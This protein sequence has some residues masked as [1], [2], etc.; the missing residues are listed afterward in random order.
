MKKEFLNYYLYISW[1]EKSSSQEFSSYMAVAKTMVKDELSEEIKNLGENVFVISSEHD[2]NLIQD[3]LKHRRFPYMLV[4]I[5]MNIS[6]SLI[7]S[8]LQSEEIEVLNTFV[9]EKKESQ[10]DY[11]K[12]KMQDCVLKEDYESAAF[13]RDLIIEAENVK[14][15]EKVIVH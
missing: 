11:L 12:Y 6:S 2:F 1:N 15:T 10:I 8:Y 3:K 5:T 4:D 9:S 13:Y 14:K 7:S